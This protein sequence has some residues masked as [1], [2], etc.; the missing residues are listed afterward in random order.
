MNLVT[1]VVVVCAGVRMR[2]LRI[3]SWCVVRCLTSFES[4]VR[5]VVVVF[6]GR[7]RFVLWNIRLPLRRRLVMNSA[8]LCGYVSVWL[9]LRIIGLLVKAYGRAGLTTWKF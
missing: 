3:I 6:R 4:C 8:V 9:V 7:V 2:L 1:Y 5:L